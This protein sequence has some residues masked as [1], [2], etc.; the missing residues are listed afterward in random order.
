[1]RT[2]VGVM[3]AM[4]AVTAPISI[5]AADRDTA[6][7]V[8]EQGIK[9]HG[10]TEALEKAQKRSR[11]GQGVIVLNNNEVPFKTE[12]TVS[13][14]DR[15]RVDLDLGRTRLVVVL[16]GDK[17]WMQAGGASQPMDKTTF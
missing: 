1:M 10:G 13:F 14:P 5:R 3:L 8:I 6:L 15:C 4:V 7:A 9:A 11:S 16:N 12:E 17:G 2:F